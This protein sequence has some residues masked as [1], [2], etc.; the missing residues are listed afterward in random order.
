M[1]TVPATTTTTAAPAASPT[2]TAAPTAGAPAAPPT[3]VPP[4]GPVHNVAVK[5]G[6]P[7]VS[8]QTITTTIVSYSLKSFNYNVQTGTAVLFV[9]MLDANGIVVKSDTIPLTVAQVDA[10]LSVAT[11]AGTLGSNLIA[12]LANAIVVHYTIANPSVVS[13]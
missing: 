11:N 6:T 9:H 3:R 7:I 13:A 8:T 1:A 5:P 10:A 4:P 2:T 12:A